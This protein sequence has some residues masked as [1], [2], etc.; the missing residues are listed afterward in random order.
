VSRF[1]WIEAGRAS[2]RDPAAALARYSG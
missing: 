2:A 1:G